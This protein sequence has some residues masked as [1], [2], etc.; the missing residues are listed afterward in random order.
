MQ[1]PT[2]QNDTTLVLSSGFEKL[3]ETPIFEKVPPLKVIPRGFQEAYG[4]TV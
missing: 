2:P 4:Q 3:V 1:V